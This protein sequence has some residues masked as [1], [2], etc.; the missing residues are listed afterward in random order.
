MPQSYGYQPPPKGRPRY[1]RSDHRVRTI[2]DDPDP[3]DDEIE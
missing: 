3:V 2:D 1:D